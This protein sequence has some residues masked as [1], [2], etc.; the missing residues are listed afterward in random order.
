MDFLRSLISSNPNQCCKLNVSQANHK[1]GIDIYFMAKHSLHLFSIEFYLLFIL[2][3][4][5]ID[6]LY[7]VCFFKRKRNVVR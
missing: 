4:L 7:M 3:R 2:L 6:E 1:L 5:N